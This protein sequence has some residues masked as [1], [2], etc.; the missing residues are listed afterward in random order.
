MATSEQVS[1]VTHT[2]THMYTQTQTRTHTHAGAQGCMEPETSS[3]YRRT[4]V[5]GWLG[6]HVL[7]PALLRMPLTLFGVSVDPRHMRTV[8]ELSGCPHCAC[9]CCLTGPDQVQYR[10]IKTVTPT[11]THRVGIPSA[12]PLRCPVCRSPQQCTCRHQVLLAVAV[13]QCHQAD[14]RASWSGYAWRVRYAC[15]HAHTH[16]HTHT[17]AQTHTHAHAGCRHCVWG[18]VN[19]HRGGGAASCCV[20]IDTHTHTHAHTHTQTHTH[21]HT[22]ASPLAFWAVAC[23]LDPCRADHLCRCVCMCMC[24]CVRVCVCHH[25]RCAKVCVR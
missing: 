19:K 5:Y 10:V 23:V 24:V 12:A 18:E 6:F 8:A 16:R 21:T 9:M 2:H 11:H 3:G 7:A 25:C 15:T 13:G 14:R 17:H 20:C 4:S 1:Y 22:H